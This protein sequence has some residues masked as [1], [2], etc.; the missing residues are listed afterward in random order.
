MRCAFTQ[1]FEVVVSRTRRMPVPRYNVNVSFDIA[2][3]R[4]PCQ[5]APAQTRRAPR[6]MARATMSLASSLQRPTIA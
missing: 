3:S 6:I 1:V 5:V 2:E 4:Q